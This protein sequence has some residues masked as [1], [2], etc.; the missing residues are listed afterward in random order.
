MP[1]ILIV[2]WEYPPLIEGGLARHVRKL[3]EAL[4]GLGVE[5]HVLTRGGEQ[6]TI[7]EEMAG[8]QIHRIVEPE[9]P[10]DLAEFVTWVERM[11]ADMLAAGVELGDR[12]DFDLVHGHDWLVAGACDHLARRFNAPLVTTI[13]ATEFGRHQGWVDKHPQ[14]HIHGVEK[15]I[16]NRSDR[17]IACSHFMREQIADIFGVEEGRIS[18]I[19]NGIDPDDLPAEDPVELAR[20]RAQFADPDENLVLLIGRLV[21][22]KGFQLALEAMPAVIEK[23]PNTR[24]LVAGSGTHEAE[25]HKQAKDL[26]LMEHGTFLGWI[27]DDVLHSL[28][29]IADLT[30]VPSIYEPFGLVALEAMASECPCIAADT[31]GLREVVPIEGAGLRFRASDP[32]HLAEAAIQVLGDPELSKRMIEEGLAHIRRFDWDEIGEQTLD[33]YEGLVASTDVRG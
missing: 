31:G 16:V 33:L 23:L 2:T 3:S 32:E 24:F 8:V 18:V 7:E 13:H 10:T 6:A 5:V 27:G 28:Y 17:V 19:P 29:R 20:L 11:N 9:R 15:W 4:V 14:S 12:F 21:Y 22:E 25:L 26:G 1:R 30:V